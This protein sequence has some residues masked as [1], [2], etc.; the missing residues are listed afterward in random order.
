[1]TAQGKT[2]SDNGKKKPQPHPSEDKF[3]D[4][5]GIRGRAAHNCRPSLKITP[6]LSSMEGRVQDAGKWAEMHSPGHAPQ[7]KGKG[8]KESEGSDGKSLG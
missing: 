6:N 2:G 4:A 5:G 8:G 3:L 7:G 1:V